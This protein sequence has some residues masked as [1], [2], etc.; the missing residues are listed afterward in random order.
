[1]ER[2]QAQELA[3]GLNSGQTYTRSIETAQGAQK[4]ETAYDSL[5]TL[6]CRGSSFGIFTDEQRET[7]REAFEAVKKLQS[8]QQTWKEAL[9]NQFDSALADV[10]A[11][12]VQMHQEAA[13]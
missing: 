4:L 8:Q 5:N 2:Q 13:A 12:A 9:D 3:S 11:D 10:A 7:L 1:M 6:V